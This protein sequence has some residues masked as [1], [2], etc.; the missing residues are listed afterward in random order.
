MTFIAPLGSGGGSVDL[1]CAITNT[2][3]TSQ[4][5][6]TKTVV[7]VAPADP[8]WDFTFTISPV[9]D[10]EVASKEA[11]GAGN[12]SSTIGWDG[13]VPG[14][15]YTIVETSLDGYDAGPLVCA[16]VTDLDDV[17]ESVT[18]VAPLNLDDGVDVACDIINT[19]R[20]GTVTVTKTA[21]GGDG[22][23][24]FDLTPAGVDPIEYQVT[25]TDG[26]G[27]VT[28]DD[29]VPGVTYTLSEVDPGSS[30]IAGDL[31]CE[32]THVDQTTEEIDFSAGYEVEIEDVIA[33]AITN[34]ARGTIVV[35]K[36][37]A[38]SDGMFD[39]TGDWTDGTP[40]PMDGA[41]TVATTDGTGS[42]TFVDVTPG[43]YSVSEVD[44]APAYLAEGLSCVDDDAD[45]TTSS[46]D[47]LVG[48]IEL[49][50]GEIVTCTF[51]NT[52]SATVVV[53]KVTDPAGDPTAFD[54]QFGPLDGDATDFALSDTDAPEVFGGLAPGDYL[55]DELVPD[56][57]LLT[58]VT[59]STEQ[60]TDGTQTTITVAAGDV[61][62]CTYTN[63]GRGDLVIDKTL[64][65]VVDN[66]DST[67]TV[68]YDLEV[69]S[70]SA[71]A[72]DYEVT[73]VL[74]FGAGVSIVS[75]TAASDDGTVDAGW[76]G[77]ADT[78]LTDGPQT[79]AARG[80]ASYR[81]EVVAA[82]TGE[83]TDAAADCVL[84]E[85]EAGTGFLNSAVV[86]WESG[87]D[88]DQA[89]GP[90]LRPGLV[91]DK[92]VSSAPAR[93][94]DGSM[95][96]AYEIAVTNT[97][98]ASTDYEL[99]DVLAFGQGTTVLDVAVTNDVPGDVSVNPGFDGGDDPFIAT[100]TLPGVGP[101]VAATH[102]YTVV[103]IA[104]V[105]AVTS[106]AARD[107]VLDPGESGT[108]FLN[109]ATVNPTAEACAEIPPT[110]L[111]P[112]PIPTPTP[113]PGL[114]RTGFELSW[115]ALLAGLLL[116]AGVG[117]RDLGS[118]ARRRR[119]DPA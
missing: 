21:V 62:T 109:R 39:F 19:G 33:C 56:G 15:T 25:T 46:I 117:I 3:Q 38:G 63:S 95:T 68:T 22:T 59:C 29:L 88:Q 115:L 12:T 7:G 31:T 55:L 83:V 13:L 43:S 106:P 14:Q 110:P 26:T 105:S 97:G 107:C 28:V 5:E 30:W 71:V 20:P 52:E 4:V 45:G 98:M 27:S 67:Q 76:D 116:L 69:T 8:D 2:A 77:V 100:A 58:D 64:T 24:T 1:G 50:P 72:E 36:N 6:V 118:N 70:D 61:V 65:G 35:V 75:A 66:G 111:T 92:T 94:P 79:L 104:D 82:L 103:V 101:G 41:F 114:P 90:I 42:A 87:Q 53:D 84:G 23:F 17:L 80:T 96:I 113:T 85:G 48:S 51:A 54:F 16:G 78:A 10:G 9:P 81:V 37:V 32:V 34:T 49:D 108:G 119:D 112:V 57:W 89:C 40:L 73:D 102:L 60:F 91:I 44:P 99:T 86:T 74:T 18:F 11:A 47:G 93:N